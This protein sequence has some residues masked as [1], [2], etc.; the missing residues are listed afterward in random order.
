MT[1]NV[2]SY[3]LPTHTETQIDALAA[4]MGMSKANVIT[5][6]VDRMSQQER[7]MYVNQMADK[8]GTVTHDGTTYTL[9]QQAYQTSRMFHGWWGDAGEGDAYT[10]E[11]E[12]AAVNSDGDECIVRWHFDAIKGEEPE[13]EGNWPWFDDNIVAVMPA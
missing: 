8:Y 10:A 1:R 2:S 9:T 11:Y 4:A 13:D 3:R 5:L 12:A 7:T 6:A